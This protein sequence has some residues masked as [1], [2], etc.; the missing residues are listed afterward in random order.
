MNLQVRPLPLQLINKVI[1]ERRDRSVVQRAESSVEHRLASVHVEL[2]TSANVVNCRDE[3][4]QVRVRV[5]GVDADPALDAD[6]C[7]ARAERQE[8]CEC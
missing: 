6:L 1:L 3:V 5:F 2:G 4:F 8:R 7:S